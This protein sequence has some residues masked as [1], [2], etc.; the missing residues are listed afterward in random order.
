MKNIS[1]KEAYKA[2]KAMAVAE[3]AKTKDEDGKSEKLVFY[4]DAKDV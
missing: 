4:A 1:L 3:A 2:L